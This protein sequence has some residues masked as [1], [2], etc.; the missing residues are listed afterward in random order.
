MTDSKSKSNTHRLLYIPIALLFLLSFIDC[1]KKGRPTG[2]ALDTIPPVILKTSPENYSI[3]FSENE[4]RITFDEYIKLKELQKNLL[5]SPPMTYAPVITPLSTSKTLKI[6]LLDTLKENTTYSINFGKSI[7]DNNEANAYDY[8]KYVFSTGSY[9]DS[10]K[11]SGTVGDIKFPKTTE[12]MTVMLYEMTE[13]FKDSLI[14]TEKPTYVTITK[15]S[16]DR[17]E[18]TNLKE[19]NY[20]LLALQEISNDFK[21]QPQ[22][23]KIGFIQDAVSLPSDSLFSLKVFKEAPTNKVRLGK[24]ETKQHIIFDYDGDTPSLDIEVI[25]EVPEAFSYR[26][27]KDAEKDSLHYWFKPALEVES[28]LFKIKNASKIDTVQVRM[29]DLFA[30]SLKINPINVGILK[31]RDT[32]F[33]RANT[34]LVAIDSEKIQLTDK[35]TLA[36]PFQAEIQTQTNKIAFTFDRAEEQTYTFNVLPGAITD[37]FEST[38]DTL[39]YRVGTKLISDYGEITVQLSNAKNFPI[40]VEL[41]DASFQP[42]DQYYLKENKEVNFGFIDPGF[43]YIRI[44]F[45]TNEN[46]QWDSG[47][48]LTRTQPEKILYYP[49]KIEV[50]PNWS[51]NE[52]FILE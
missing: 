31:P 40:L 14:Y 22:T 36:V 18:L 6:Q 43:Y 27:F 48:F 4:I 52:T 23:D 37:F 29:R 25:S 17:F 42:V 16:T 51:L 30:D 20:L 33:L 7:V 5:I 1:A 38:N 50:K 28:L 8:Y 45:D 11:L 44:I 34:P 35:D 26:S 47:H 3:N 46:G 13:D 21:Y 41:V 2:G 24:H 9:I 49:S 32:F 12:P 10:L 39:Q 15:D 19:G